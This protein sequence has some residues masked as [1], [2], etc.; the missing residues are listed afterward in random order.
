[1]IEPLLDSD[2]PAGAFGKVAGKKVK[3]LPSSV[4][5]SGLGVWGIRLTPFSQEEYHKRIN[6]TYRHRDELKTLEKNA[7]TRGDDV[8]VDKGFK[9]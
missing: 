8:D 2:D 9:N 3:R 7:K 6:E 4:Y 5:W 1:M